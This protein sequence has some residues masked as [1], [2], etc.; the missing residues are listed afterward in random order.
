MD[1]SVA[2][3]LE[4]RKPAV[5]ANTLA[6]PVSG[7]RRVADGTLKSSVNRVFRCSME[8]GVKVFREETFTSRRQHTSSAYLTFVPIEEKGKPK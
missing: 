4:G 2:L 8:V 1:R 3:D 5:S 6:S 7:V